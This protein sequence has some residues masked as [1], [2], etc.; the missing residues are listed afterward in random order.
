MN[1]ITNS[2]SIRGQVTISGEIFVQNCMNYPVCIADARQ[3]AAT[4][5]TAPT[6]HHDSVGNGTGTH[7]SGYEG[8]KLEHFNACIIGYYTN[9]QLTIDAKSAMLSEAVFSEQLGEQ[10]RLSNAAQ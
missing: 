4:I 9:K 7:T 8:D 2:P 6:N 10:L 3:P 5:G 1:G